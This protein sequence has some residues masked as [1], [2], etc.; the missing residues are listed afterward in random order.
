M[1][2]V[3]RVLHCLDTTKE[4]SPLNRGGPSTTSRPSESVPQPTQQSAQISDAQLSLPDKYA[5]TPSKCCVFLLQC[6]LY[7][8]H[9]TGATV[10]S[11]LTGLG[12]GVG[13]SHLGER[14]GS[15]LC[16]GL[17][18]TIHRRVEREVSDYSNSGRVPRPVW[19]TLSASGPWQ[20]TADWDEPALPILFRKGL[21]KKVQ[22]ELECWDDILSLDSLIV[23]AIRLD[24]LL[25][26]S[27]RTPRPPPLAFLR[28]SLNP[29]R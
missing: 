22:M 24:N 28:Q 8:A 23:M 10:I 2:E 17:S 25:C 27:R 29:W 11:L 3:L 21:R 14:R 9:Q 19:S 5:G 4:D 1:D 12:V 13:Y 20:P 18:S 6:S 16:S 7:F 26:E 15:R